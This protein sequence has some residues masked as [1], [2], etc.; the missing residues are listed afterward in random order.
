MPDVQN[1]DSVVFHPVGDDVWQARVKKLARALFPA[2][3]SAVWEFFQRT[4][5]LSEFNERGTGQVGFMFIEV[6]MD[7][8]QILCGRGRPTD[9]H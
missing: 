1:L 7:C 3:A 2:F 6:L 8:V 5:S 4:H 9:A